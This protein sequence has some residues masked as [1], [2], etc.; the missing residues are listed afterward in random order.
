MAAG[1]T[2][3]RFAELNITRWHTAYPDMK[4]I[5]KHSIAHQRPEKARGLIFNTRRPPFDDIRVRAAL[6]MLL[7][8][9]WIAKNIYYGEFKPINSYFLNPLAAQIIESPPPSCRAAI[10]AA[11]NKLDEAGW[12]IDNGKRVKDGKLFALRSSQPEDEKDRT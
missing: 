1:T 11:Y 8:R 7:D 3:I 9:D 6:N 4:G 2:N 5:V 12:I 10:R